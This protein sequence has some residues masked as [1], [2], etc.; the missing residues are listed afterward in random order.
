MRLKNEIRIVTG[1]AQGIGAATME[2]FAAEG[3]ICIGCDRRLGTIEGA[4]ET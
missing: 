1:A 4:S 3:A 2:K